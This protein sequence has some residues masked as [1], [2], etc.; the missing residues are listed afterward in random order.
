MYPIYKW[1]NKLQLAY[2]VRICQMFTV[3]ITVNL[4]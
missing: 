4:F 1:L 3:Y 2:V